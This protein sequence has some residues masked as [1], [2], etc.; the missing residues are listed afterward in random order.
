MTE[1]KPE[2]T[3]VAYY[4]PC[5]CIAGLCVDMRDKETA[6]S[7]SGWIRKG[8]VVKHIHE[9]ELKPIFDTIKKNNGLGCRCA[10]N[11]LDLFGG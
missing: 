2:Y 9:S 6:S 8:C 10:S 1:K 5:G 4:F 11:Q 3:Y 7:V